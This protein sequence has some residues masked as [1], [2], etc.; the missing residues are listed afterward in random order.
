MPLLVIDNT[1]S[2]VDQLVDELS[3]ESCRLIRVL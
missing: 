1:A 3:E 2:F